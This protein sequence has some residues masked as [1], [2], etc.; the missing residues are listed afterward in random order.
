MS[1]KK[2]TEKI[3]FGLLFDIGGGSTELTFFNFIDKPFSSKSC[4]LSFGVINLSEK[5][6]I[7][8]P[9][10]NKKLIQRYV[11]D[12]YVYLKMIVLISPQLVLVVP[13]QQ[14]AQYI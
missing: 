8:G 5:N 12:F 3:K 11:N 13:W 7:Y 10:Y 2:Y 4:S 9:D 1:C 14:Y 6:E